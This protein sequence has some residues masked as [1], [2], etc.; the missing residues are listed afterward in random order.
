M[1]ILVT[2]GQGPLRDLLQVLAKSSSR[3]PGEIF[4]VSSHALV[5]VVVRRSCADL[6]ALLVEE[7]L[8]CVK[9]LLEVL[10]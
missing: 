10:V 9:G 7:V 8:A 2:R 5:Q 1:Q 6:V 4:T 3:R